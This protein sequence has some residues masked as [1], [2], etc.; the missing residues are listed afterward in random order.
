MWPK[1]KGFVGSMSLFSLTT[2]GLASCPWHSLGSSL[3]WA[4]G[5]GPV[6]TLALSPDPPT[7]ADHMLPQWPPHSQH[8]SATGHLRL[9]LASLPLKWQ[10]VMGVQTRRMHWSVA[11][12]SS[13]ESLFLGYSRWQYDVLGWKKSPFLDTI[14]PSQKPKHMTSEKYD[15]SYMSWL[16]YPICVIRFF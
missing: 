6:A 12:N 1:Q 11:L 14:S 9:R 8:A 15:F 2:R 10:T 13:T 7:Q 3:L 16:H 4:L 5:S